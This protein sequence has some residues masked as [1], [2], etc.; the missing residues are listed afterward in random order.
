M[1]SYFKYYIIKTQQARKS[2]V[3]KLCGYAMDKVR[4]RCRSRDGNSDTFKQCGLDLC[5]FGSMVISPLIEITACQ[6]WRVLSRHSVLSKFDKITHH[7][8]GNLRVEYK[9]PGLLVRLLCRRSCL[10]GVLPQVGGCWGLGVLGGVE[11]S[12]TTRLANVPGRG[13]PTN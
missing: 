12:L 8:K 6:S 4:W 13:T 7:R 1:L 2:I 5:P 10:G 9:R 3:L 11:I